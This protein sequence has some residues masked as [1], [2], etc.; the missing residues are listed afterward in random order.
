MK[1]RFLSVL[2]ALALCLTLLPTA[3]LAAET[4]PRRVTLA[5]TP[6]ESGKSYVPKEGGGIK[7]KTDQSDANYL[8]YAD[9]VLTVHGTVA[10]NCNNGDGLSFYDGV[11]TLAG[12]GDL[13]I[14]ASSDGAVS[15]SPG[16]TLTTAEG[17]SGSITL[18]S[19][20]RS[21]VQ[22]VKLELTTEGDI[23]ISS[24]ESNAVNT[25]QNPVTLKGET[26]T[27]E[28]TADSPVSVSTVVAPSL[29]VIA[30]SDVT[31]I[32]NGGSYPLIAGDS[33]KECAVTLS[34]G[35]NV[36]IINKSGSAVFGPLTVAK[37]VNVAI[38]GGSGNSTLLPSASTAHSITASGTVQMESNGIVFSGNS[39]GLTIQDAKT[40]E[41]SGE[42][43][44]APVVTGM[45]LRGCGT[46]SV[47]RLVG[48][49][50]PAPIADNINSDIPVLLYNGPNDDEPRLL[51]KN[52]TYQKDYAVGGEPMEPDAQKAV[53]YEARNGYVMFSRLSNSDPKNEAASA[54]L[55][56]AESKYEGIVGNLTG[57]EVI[58]ENSLSEI[59]ALD[60]VGTK[61]SF[62]GNGTLHTLFADSVEPEIAD[63]VAFHGLVCVM[64]TEA[65]QEQEK[66]IISMNFTAYGTSNLPPN[67]WESDQ[68]PGKFVV[69]TVDS[70]EAIAKIRLTVPKGATLTI[71]GNMTLEISGLE[72]LSRLTNNGTLV[73][74]GTVSI[75]D[76]TAE[77]IKGLRLTGS[78]VVRVPA[79]TDYTYYTNGGNLKMDNLDLSQTSGDQGDLKNDGYHWDNT[80]RILTLNGLAVTGKLTLPNGADDIKIAVQKESLV[81]EL[82]YTDSYRPTIQI[83]GPAPLTVKQMSS[84]VG[85]RLTVE[86]GAALNAGEINIGAAGNKDSIITVNGKLTVK[87]KGILCGKMVIGA[88][89]AVSVSGEC[90]V[91][92]GGVTVVNNDMTTDT[93][94]KD[95]FKIENGGTFSA[96][97]TEYNVMVFTEGTEIDEAKAKT[98]LVLPENYLP[99]DYSI[100]VVT[101]DSGSDKQYAATVAHKGANLTLAAERVSGAGGSLELKLPTAPKPGTGGG[102]ADGSTG[103]GSSSGGGG[104]SSSSS[105]PSTNTGTTTKPDGTKVQTETKADGTKIQTETKK[106]GSTVKT[107]TNPNGSSVTET[108]AA[109]GSTGTVKT[110]KHGQTEANAKVSAKAVEDAK[111]SGEAVKAPVEVEASR[112][113]NTAPTVKVELPKNSGETKV[114][115]PVS[116]VKPGTVA[117][118]VH[119]DGTEE[120]VKNSVPTEDGIQL[121]VD[122]SATVK[123][124]DN[125][126]D[127]IDTRNHWAREEIDFV[128][129]RELVNGMNDSIYAPNA[130]ATR[131]QLWT[132]LARQNDADLNGGNTWYEKAQLWSKDKGISDGT[133]PD[134][135]INR[136]QMVTMLWRTM[137][138]PAAGGAANF[139][140][141]PANS[142]YAQAVAW[143]VESGITTGVGGGR[144]DPA[145]TCTRAQIATFLA[146]SMK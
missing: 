136:A 66:P 22:N 5:W 129:A 108:K 113:S 3:A 89:G 117:V 32:G 8:T 67:V 12:D 62:T 49:E 138:Q 77:D 13:T 48:S 6:L 121:T 21:A 96:N 18:R 122:G 139:N 75:P 43:T 128:S 24:A 126:K 68:D 28:T 1:K 38:E 56:N 86:Q 31:I 29:N 76:A 104:S 7:E 111:K 124:V 109:D 79:G 106:D 145:A 63:S 99:E 53:Y 87:G 116:N 23:Q 19:E 52:D 132:I 141:V 14:T 47:T 142:Y 103:G 46:A 146:R 2:T 73:N 69:G 137:G 10:V 59:Q 80:N 35:G 4:A 58:G 95:A 93:S 71:P 17:F 112:N 88:T 27:I 94:F 78:G 42:K 51:W 81:N 20:N 55:F 120:I 54:I 33:G 82:P 57:I 110:D 143:A 74:D 84:G 36:K 30:G 100:Q 127:F 92:V 85:I 40:V 50:A 140:D 15:G 123:I 37:A 45:T 101:D 144:F 26:V 118:I 70:K 119:P 90:G 83:V 11:L 107:T 133:Q 39:T 134:A 125:S 41:I 98:Y 130:S 97:C 64:T 44:S 91:K 60:D 115:I 65:T 105:K 9:G 61:V 16:S 34:A 102:S 72:H 131:A 25:P 135:A 114:E